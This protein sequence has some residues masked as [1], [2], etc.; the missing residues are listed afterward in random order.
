MVLFGFVDVNSI[1]FLTT[2]RNIECS[3]YCYNYQLIYYLEE[4]DWLKCQFYVLF[5]RN[6]HAFSNK[7]SF[8][9]IYSI[10][11]KHN[12]NRV[13]TVRESQEENSHFQWSQES[14]RKL[15][16][17]GNSSGGQR[18]RERERSIVWNLRVREFLI[19]NISDFMILIHL[20]YFCLLI[21]KIKTRF[22]KL[23]DFNNLFQSF[24]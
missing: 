8:C 20:K 21:V 11:S 4:F 7:C 18:E 19:S 14:Q 5:W 15:E 17:S 9:F 23:L 16:E 12:C 1:S 22:D 6:S 3:F 2:F 24:L 10:T 13:G